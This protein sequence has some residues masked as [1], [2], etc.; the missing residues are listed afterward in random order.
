MGD[1]VKVTGRWMEIGKEIMGIVRGCGEIN[2]GRTGMGAGT[3]G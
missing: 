1:A 2:R 3:M